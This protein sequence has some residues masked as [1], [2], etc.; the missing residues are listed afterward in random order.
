MGTLSQQSRGTGGNAAALAELASKLA[1]YNA[2]LD[3]LL[4]PQVAAA[5]RKQPRGRIFNP[6]ARPSP[7]APP[8]PGG[9]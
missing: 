3:A 5:Y 7:P 4:G 6:P 1:G 8:T 2:R 9:G